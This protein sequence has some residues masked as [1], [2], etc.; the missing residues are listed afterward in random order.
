MIHE[1]A[2]ARVEE[3]R[4]EDGKSI[5]FVVESASACEIVRSVVR[6]NAGAG[7][8]VRNGSYPH[9]RNLQIIDVQSRG[10]QIVDGGGTFD[11]CEVVG[12]RRTSVAVSG[13]SNPTVRTTVI[14]DGQSIGLLIDEGASGSYSDCMITGHVVAGISIRGGSSPSVSSVRVIESAG[15]GVHV[16]RTAGGRIAGCEVARNVKGDWHIEDGSSVIC[17]R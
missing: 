4:I 13:T 12:S 17:A 7:L 11:A 10:L 15:Y 9:V 1:E 6:R 5:G 16:D 14:R 3:M 8:I 2:Y